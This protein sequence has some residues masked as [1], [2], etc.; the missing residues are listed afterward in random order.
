PG[1]H[2][3]TFGGNPFACAIALATINAMDEGGFMENAS[4]IGEY[5]LGLL[6]DA[7]ADCAGVSEVRGQG[8]MIGIELD[9]PCAML[10]QQALQQGIL[11]NVTAGQVIRLLPPLILQ[12]KEADVLVST[13][14]DLIRK[15][16]N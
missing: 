2:G 9:R 16:V 1:M 4:M 3:T 7:L 11:I 8:L 13:L 14:V 15:F 5:I 10:V 6:N 12:K